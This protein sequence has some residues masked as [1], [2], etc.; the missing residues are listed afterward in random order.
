MFMQDKLLHKIND[1]Y[2][3]THALTRGKKYRVAIV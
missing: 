3:Q 2:K 1:N